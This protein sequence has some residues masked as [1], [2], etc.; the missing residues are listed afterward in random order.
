MLTCVP[1]LVQF[2]LAGDRN[3][4]VAFRS[5]PAGVQ[6]G[7]SAGRRQIHPDPRPSFWTL[8]RVAASRLAHG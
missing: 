2:L 6:L 3:T 8:A 4:R 5:E 7:E 1:S